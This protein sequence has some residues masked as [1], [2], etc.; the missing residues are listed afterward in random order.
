[1]FLKEF[2]NIDW[3]K[4]QIATN[5]SSPNLDQSLKLGWPTV[6]LNVETQNEER[7]NLKGPYSLF[8]NLSGN[9]ILNVDQREVQLGKNCFG[10]S[11]KDQVYN[12]IY[13]K[14]EKAETLNVHLGEEFLNSAFHYLRAKNKNA[15]DLGEEL[16]FDSE[17]P[18]RSHFVSP[19]IKNQI[20]LLKSVYER[21]SDRLEREECLFHLFQMVN[22]KG[23]IEARALVDLNPVKPSTKKELISRLYKAIDFMH[24]NFSKNL[25]LSELAQVA[26]LSKFHFL[27]MFKN[28]FGISPYQYLRKLRLQE[29]QKHL[30]SEGVSLQILA[31][32]VGFANASSLSRAYQMEFGQWPRKNGLKK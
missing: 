28:L 22:E 19:D 14:K 5:F 23:R 4:K 27:R 25:D 32:K 10:I 26:C 3:L 7:R 18:I 16:P 9:G 1:M 2:P 11:N 13:P 15:W 8:F 6:V 17:I 31:E 20:H 12:L 29:V 21:S 24:Y 30:N